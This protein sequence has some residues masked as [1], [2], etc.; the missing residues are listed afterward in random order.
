MW[1][2]I[3]NIL[4]RIEICTREIVRRRMRYE[5]VT[6][7]LNKCSVNE[8]ERL[9]EIRAAC[10]RFVRVFRR[11]GKIRVRS[12]LNGRTHKQERF[13]KRLYNDSSERRN[14]D[15]CISQRAV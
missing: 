2:Q 15:T 9:T 3:I 14:D 6:V 1:C 13:T 10:V 7:S 11:D 8:T 4:I 12:I 5:F